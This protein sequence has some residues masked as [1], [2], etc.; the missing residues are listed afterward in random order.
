MRNYFTA[1]LNRMAWKIKKAQNIS[2]G[3]AFR[4]AMTLG[5][6]QEHPEATSVFG[7]WT[8]ASTKAVAGHFWGLS[9]AYAE[10]G[11]TGRSI[12]MKKVSSTLYA[13]YEEYVPVSFYSLIRQKGVK[14]SIAN[15]IVAYFSAASVGG[16]T[17]RTKTLIGQGA[18]AYAANVHAARWNF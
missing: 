10:L 6:V 8:P 17:D 1:D 15:E 5:Q 2:W 16:Y 18:R 4:M 12:A 3:A 11:D 13:Q 7:T 9:K 14:E